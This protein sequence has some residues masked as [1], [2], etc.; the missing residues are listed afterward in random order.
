MQGSREPDFFIAD[1]R[2]RPAL[3]QLERGGAVVSVEARSLQVLA[4]LARHVPNVVSKQCLIREV[5]G[6]AF[7][8]D[9]VLSHAIWELRKAFGDEARQPRY[10]QTFAKKGYR[11][12][13]EVS[14]SAAP[15]P[16]AAGCRIGHYEILEAIGGGAMGE[17]YK[18]RDLRLD[19]VVALKF[20]PAE[21]ARDPSARRRF[22]REAQ[23]VAQLDHPNV[24]TI[25]E[26]GESE[27][28]RA[29]LALAFYEGETLQQKLAQEP[30]PLPETIGIARQIAQGLAAAHRRQIVHRDIK[31][32][33]I[34]VLPD[35][36]VKLL[37][38]GL[39]KLAGA[40]TLT[41]LGSS[42]GTPAYKSPEQTRGEKVDPRSDLWALGVVLYEMVTGRVPFGGD[43]EQA[44]I[45]AILNEPPR[46]LEAGRFPPELVAV[47]E[48]ALAKD[49][50]ARYATAEEM[51]E[52][53]GRVPLDGE[54]KTSPPR[55]APARRRLSV[56]LGLWIVAALALLVVLGT[57]AAVRYRW[58]HRWDYSPEVKRLVEQGD[59]IEWRGDTESVFKNA[60]NTYR[61]A[62]ALDRGNPLIE[63]QLA[64]LLCRFESQF[65]DP[66]RRQE[67][68]RL[69]AKAVEGA[70]DDPMPWV[71]QAKLL[72]LEDR[73][74]EAERAARKAVEQGPDFDR[75]YTMLGEALIT[76]GHLDEGLGKIRQ[77]V[78]LDQGYL[79]ARLVLA[80]RLQEAS[81]YNEAAT[82]YRKVLEYDP[83]H[84][85]ANQNLGEIYLANR[86]NLEALPLF[87]K[88]LEATHDPRAANSLGLA[89]LNLERM[90]EAIKTLGEAYRLEPDPITARNLAECYER[91]G[92]RDE[93]RRWYLLALNSFDRMLARGGSRTDL[94]YVRSFC[95][96]K[97]GRFAEALGNIQEAMRLNP[98]QSSFLFRI[99]QIQAIAGHR[100]E[101]YEYTRRAILAGY[102]RAGFREDFVFR[103]LQNDPQFRTIL[104]SAAR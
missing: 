4:C 67:I 2:V 80:Y 34:V 11:L 92:K 83:D 66:N 70:P 60:A 5:W 17:V 18:A 37:D 6:E 91:T 49:P 97:L 79:R 85:T 8:T 101:V 68:R 47:I 38:F 36:T 25:Y 48:R 95:A 100:N 23:A 32:A 99:A 24:A 13:A 20:L 88:V 42:P 52:D 61:K 31:P 102:P 82:E 62:L 14:F 33:N 77:A 29:F 19:R 15:E 98:N 12:L 72:L 78:D 46:P 35:G 9:E 86:Q 58:Q 84:P 103:S 81:R 89:Y 74:K 30:L 26:T 65:P 43:Y 54:H 16:L 75:G 28:G 1:W 22:L 56:R 3:G 104:E 50:A 69:I 90:P 41:R 59:R 76:Q 40:T 7:V 55:P 63:A 87:R 73:P 39:A 44:V 57:V 45:Y 94:L 21:L 53:L 96:A 27:G 71:A 64:A 93:A 51:E 10:I